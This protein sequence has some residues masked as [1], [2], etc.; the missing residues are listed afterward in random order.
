MADVRRMAVFTLH[1]PT[2]YVQSVLD[3]AFR[4]YIAT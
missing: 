1:Q 2:R 4:H 3:L